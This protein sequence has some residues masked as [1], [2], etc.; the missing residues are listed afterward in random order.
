MS[1]IL[2]LVIICVLLYC[3]SRN[4]FFEMFTDYQIEKNEGMIK[5]VT[6]PEIRGEREL[7]L[8]DYLFFLSNKKPLLCSQLIQWFIQPTP[9]PD[10]IWETK[11]NSIWYRI[12]NPM[13]S[14]DW[15]M[16]KSFVSKMC[17]Q[18]NQVDYLFWEK[19]KPTIRK[20]LYRREYIFSEKRQRTNNLNN[21]WR[22]TGDSF[23]PLS[24]EAD[25]D[26]VNVYNQDLQNV[27]DSLLD[28]NFADPTVFTK[29][30]TIKSYVAS[31]VKPAGWLYDKDISIQYDQDTDKFDLQHLPLNAYKNRIWVNRAERNMNPMSA[32][33]PIF[34]NQN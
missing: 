29:K 20:E 4:T 1:Y 7:L 34:E 8:I 30:E 15:E 28:I 9:H 17:Q 16:I 18:H 3:L 11:R 25:I 6:F 12:V 31:D 10:E 14:F 23:H 19:I 33:V 26:W 32:P 13:D 5:K 2:Y 21:S 24:N 27:N 22:K